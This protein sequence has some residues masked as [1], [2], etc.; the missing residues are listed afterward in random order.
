MASLWATGDTSDSCLLVLV[1]IRGEGI[2]S[3]E[4][5]DGEYAFEG[6]CR[7]DGEAA[8]G[9]GEGVEREGVRLFERGGEGKSKSWSR[10]QADRWATDS[11]AQSRSAHGLGDLGV[12]CSRTVL[13]EVSEGVVVFERL[14]LFP[15]KLELEG[16]D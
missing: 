4:T 13:T 16:A 15:N 10:K 11:E 5:A 1:K 2:I 6:T 14:E 9:R 3:G 8:A 12:L 7:E